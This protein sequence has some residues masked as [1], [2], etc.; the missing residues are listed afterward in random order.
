M[1]FTFLAELLFLLPAL[2]VVVEEA[3]KGDDDDD[4][5]DEEEEEDD[6]DDIERAAE[7]A[8]GMVRLF[9]PLFELLPLVPLDCVGF[10][11]SSTS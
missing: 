3:V 9:L 2:E 1:V 7:D 11:P 4:D 8:V 10:L 6:A 5:D